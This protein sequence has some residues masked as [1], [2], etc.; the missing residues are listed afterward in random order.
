MKFTV[1]HI[2]KY[3]I[4]ITL[5]LLTTNIFSQYSFEWALTY[6]GGGWDEATN[7]IQLKNGNLLVSGSMRIE[8]ENMWLLKVDAITGKA[9]WGKTFPGY[10]ISRACDL[11]ETTDKNIVLAGYTIDNDEVNKRVWVLKI[12]TIGNII[13]E[14]N[15]GEDL[16][17]QAYSVIQTQDDG[18]IVCGSTTSTISYTL[19]WWILKL[20]QNGDIVWEKQFGGSKEDIAKSAAELSD[21]SIA[22]TGFVGS[23]GGGYH[24]ISV[25]KLD[26][27]GNEIWYNVYRVNDWDEATSI[28]ATHDDNLAVAGFSRQAAITDY[29][30]VVIKLN[31]EGDT[32]WQRIFGRD[33]F[34]NT[35]NATNIGYQKKTAGDY[36]KEYWDEAS[37]IIE[38]YDD[39]IV[40]AGFSK[41]NELMKS[42]YM[43]VK[44]NASGE[45][46]WYDFFNRQSLDIGK[47]IIETKENALV[48][49]GV[50]YSIGN[51]WDY[52]L[53]KY[54]SGEKST[55]TINNPQDSVLTIIQDTIVLDICIN[56]YRKP[57]NL[58]VSNNSVIQEFINVFPEKDEI[59]EC[60][61]SMQVKLNLELGKNE[62]EFK[63]LDEKKYE[64]IEKR[65]IY[66]LPPP[67]KTW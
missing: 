42:D 27:D 56:S 29:D 19:D 8:Q 37:D 7:I 31:A 55:L 38:C 17:A 12:D 25:I 35:P 10:Y 3:F 6:G 28:I 51:A 5:I 16:D 62:I 59:G 34:R 45:L 30:A 52:A 33:Y 41:A 67:S 64:F 53:L 13:W 40:I 44:Y 46:I 1:K 54:T 2:K 43:V 60:P 66:Y 32:L 18:F 26:K 24:S 47:S 48:I 23:A 15:F 58:T 21:G 63:A 11:V 14:K 65:I 50:T 20:D 61:F 36:N 49:C 4:L 57:V 22:V 39:G 9:L